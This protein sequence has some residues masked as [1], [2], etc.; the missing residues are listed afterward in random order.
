MIEILLLETPST[1]RDISA[2]IDIVPVDVPA[3]LGLEVL[4]SEQLYL[5]NVTNGL[6]HRAVLSHPGET[7]QYKDKY[8]VPLTFQNGHLY[9]R[10]GFM[11]YKFY[12]TAQL[13]K[14][15]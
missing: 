6:V 15:H 4:D 1:W 5:Y 11:N 8:S 10:M 14:L 7:L 2:L 13:Q 12:T 9:A 3:L